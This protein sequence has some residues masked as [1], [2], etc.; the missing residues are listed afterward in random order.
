MDANAM[1]CSESGGILVRQFE[2]PRGDDV[3]FAGRVAVTR[4]PPSWTVEGASDDLCTPK[5]QSDA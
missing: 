2:G 4:V 1:L 5:S 3:S